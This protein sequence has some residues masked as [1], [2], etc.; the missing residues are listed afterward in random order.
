MIPQS[1]EKVHVHINE[2]IA[3]ITHMRPKLPSRY[4]NHF[5]MRPFS[6]GGQLYEMRDA[7]RLKIKYN[8]DLDLFPS[9]CG[10]DIYSLRDG[11]NALERLYISKQVFSEV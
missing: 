4:M 8:V 1:S 6:A 5:S 9:L 11:Y 10:D 3:F 7:Q 2:E